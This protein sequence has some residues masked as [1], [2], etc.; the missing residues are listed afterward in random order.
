MKPN[1]PPRVPGNTEWERFDNA[2]SKV[3]SVSK[4]DF[5]K[6]EKK[7]LKSKRKKKS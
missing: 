2:V 6:E 5:Y 7:K 3:L 4:E 1:P